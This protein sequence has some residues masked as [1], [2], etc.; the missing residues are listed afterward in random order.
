MSN[1]GIKMEGWK[2]EENLKPEPWTTVL[3]LAGASVLDSSNTDR[4]S[5]SVFD[6]SSCDR[7]TVE[8]FQLNNVW[9]LLL[10]TVRPHVQQQGE[11]EVNK[12]HLAVHLLVTGSLCTLLHVCLTH[13]ASE[14]IVLI[15]K[16]DKNRVIMIQELSHDKIVMLQEKEVKKEW[17]ILQ[18]GES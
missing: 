7:P 14:N 4:R 11:P 12:V 1:N 15:Y 2:R 9:S 17:G 6:L 18:R 5:R 13:G 10:S 16:K 3:Y 8:S